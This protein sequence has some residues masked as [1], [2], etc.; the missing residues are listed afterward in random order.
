MDPDWVSIPNDTSNSIRVY[1]AMGDWVEDWKITSNENLIRDWNSFLIHVSTIL[2]FRRFL[3][4]I[5]LNTWIKLPIFFYTIF[6]SAIMNVDFIPSFIQEWNFDPSL[7]DSESTFLS[8]KNGMNLIR[9]ELQPQSG[10]CFK[11]NIIHFLYVC[12]VNTIYLFSFVETPR[13]F[14]IAELSIRKLGSSSLLIIVK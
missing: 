13:K 2:V 14:I 5:H 1:V 12:M 3:T 6:I 9:N 7:H 8:M 10:S 4:L 11:T